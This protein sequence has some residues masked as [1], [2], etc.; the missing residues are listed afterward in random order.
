MPGDSVD[1]T[2]ALRFNDPT[3]VAAIVFECWPQVETFY[4][5]GRPG[6]ALLRFFVKYDAH[7]EWNDGMGVEIVLSMEVLP[8]RYT[9]VE[10]GSAQYIE[11]HFRLR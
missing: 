4:P 6:T 5:M 10:A 2:L 8:C 7:A 1:N 9:R 3:T 11:R